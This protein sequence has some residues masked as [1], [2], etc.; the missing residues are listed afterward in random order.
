M[1]IIGL[2]NWVTLPILRIFH[3]AHPKNISPQMQ[4]HLLMFYSSSVYFWYLETIETF[5][6][7]KQLKLLKQLK[8]LK[9]LKLLKLLNILQLAA[10]SS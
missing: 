1:G 7:I 6:T 5:E 4:L 9:L 10:F 8:P 3:F 2:K